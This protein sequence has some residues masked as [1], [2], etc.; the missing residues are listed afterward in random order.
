MV[1]LAGKLIDLVNKEFARKK[2]SQ[3][4]SNRTDYKI[5]VAI[6]RIK[7]NFE[8]LSNIHNSFYQNPESWERLFIRLNNLCEEYKEKTGE[9]PEILEL[10]TNEKLIRKYLDNDR[11]FWMKIKR[12]DRYSEINGRDERNI[13]QGLLD[14]YTG[15]LTKV[16]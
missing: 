10:M 4:T 6:G 5:Q 8:I 13:I 11:D 3:N 14:Y 12:E 1:S 16:A 7:G 2:E 15:K 9:I